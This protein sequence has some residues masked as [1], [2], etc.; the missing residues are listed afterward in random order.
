[1]ASGWNDFCGIIR[2]NNSIPADMR[3]L[4][5]L[6]SGTLNNAA[7]QWI[8][9][10]P[11][12]RSAGLT[13][14]QLLEIRLTPAF[15]GPVSPK[16]HLTPALSAAMNFADWVTKAVYVPQ[17]VYDSLKKY[18]SDMQMVD[19]T[20]TVGGYNFVS[21]FVVALNVDGK[22]DTPVPIPR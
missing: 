8:Q 15:L 4:L 18:L 12:G 9:H 11:V 7:Y 14:E 3:E 20:A 13:T 10:E 2:D 6:R 16:T 17:P 22:M 5:I 1:M 19:A 21:R